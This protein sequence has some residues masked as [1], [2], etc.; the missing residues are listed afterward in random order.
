MQLNLSNN[1]CPA[2]I[3]KATAPLAGE[4]RHSPAKD[5]RTQGRFYPEKYNVAFPKM[6]CLL[7]AG[8]KILLI[9]RGLIYTLEHP[10]MKLTSL[11]THSPPANTSLQRTTAISLP[12]PASTGSSA[13]QV[14]EL[15]TRSH[16]KRKMTTTALLTTS[17]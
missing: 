5:Y 13:T 17:D 15:P 7:D 8:R 3:Q 6:C 16:L 9:Y 4:N 1:E 14:H 12:L 2:A 11:T 10:P